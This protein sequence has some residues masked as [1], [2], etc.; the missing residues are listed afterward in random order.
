MQLLGIIINSETAEI[1]EKNRAQ[2]PI[3]TGIEARG[4]ILHGPYFGV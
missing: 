3:N 1:S 2:M 4:E